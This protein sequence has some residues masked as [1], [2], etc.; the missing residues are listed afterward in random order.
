MK[1]IL[2]AFLAAASTA[3]D[4]IY[5]GLLPIYGEEV[6]AELPDRCIII[7]IEDVKWNKAFGR[8]YELKATL[9][10]AYYMPLMALDRDSEIN[11]IY[12]QCCEALDMIQYQDYKFA[13]HEKQRSEQNGVLHIKCPFA[14]HL[15]KVPDDPVMGKITISGGT[16]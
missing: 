7:G 9:D 4:T 16:T 14:T 5:G 11:R 3:L 13:L 12:I 2:N 8:R 15:Y 1:D 10:V 6:P